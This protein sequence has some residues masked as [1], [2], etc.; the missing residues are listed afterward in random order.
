M[1][2]KIKTKAAETHDKMW[3]CKHCGQSTFDVD[4]DYLCAPDEHLECFK[5]D[6]NKKVNEQM[7][8]FE[9]SLKEADWGHQPG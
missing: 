5:A 6:E 9:E 1:P 7:E 3:I 8:R 4:Y 2:K